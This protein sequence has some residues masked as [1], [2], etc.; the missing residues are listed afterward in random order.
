MKKII[1][2]CLIFLFS[3]SC[4]YEPLISKNKNFSFKIIDLG[5]NNKINYIVKNRLKIYEEKNNNNYNLEIIDSKIRKIVAS[6]D[7]KGNPKTYRLTI[8][9][10]INLK[11]NS[12]LI[13]KDKEFLSSSN[14]NTM[15]SKF[16]LKKYEENLIKNLTEKILDNLILYMQNL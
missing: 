10:N 5:G 16:E 14:Y 2:I 3:S 1:I 9:L 15:S 4:G 8:K 6:M 12:N 7:T 11:Q 13:G